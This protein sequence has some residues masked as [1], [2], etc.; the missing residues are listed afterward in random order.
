M[1]LSNVLLSLIF[2]AQITQIVLNFSIRDSKQFT[3]PK[4]MPYESRFD[5]FTGY[6]N[7]ISQNHSVEQ[8]GVFKIDKKTGE[9]WKWVEVFNENR[10]FEGWSRTV[11]RD[12][13]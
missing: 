2:I 12:K 10:Y 3:D 9:V 1:R 13:T 7:A 6:Y 4:N 5:L 8:K 11:D